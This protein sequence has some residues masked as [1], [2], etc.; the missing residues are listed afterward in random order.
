M[1][2]FFHLTESS[3]HLGERRLTTQQGLHAQGQAGDEEQVV[4]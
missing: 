2:F 1:L 4:D 3:S